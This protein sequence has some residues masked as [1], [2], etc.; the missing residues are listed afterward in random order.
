VEDVLPGFL[1]GVWFFADG[2]GGRMVVVRAL[3][4]PPRLEEAVVELQQSQGFMVVHEEF[5]QQRRGEDH[6]V[7]F[8]RCEMWPAGDGGRARLSLLAGAIESW[9]GE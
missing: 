2:R 3:L 9:R 1:G 7:K 6:I 5:E 8:Q 4:D